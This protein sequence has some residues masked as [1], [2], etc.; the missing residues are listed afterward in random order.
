M[1]QEMNKS[2]FSKKRIEL[3]WTKKWEKKWNKYT[4]TA[5]ETAVAKKV[6]PSYIYPQSKLTDKSMRRR[7]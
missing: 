5:T 6:Q 1:K 4:A 3:V 7:K 2:K